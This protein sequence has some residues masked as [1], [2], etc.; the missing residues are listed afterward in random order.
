MKPMSSWTRRSFLSTA[1]VAAPAIIT[2]AK[3]AAPDPAVE[4]AKVVVADALAALGGDKFLEMK[5]RV[6]EGRA[7]SFY[8]SRLAGLSRAKIYTRYLDTTSDKG[9]A[10]RE[11]QAFGKDEDQAVLFNE[12]GEGWEITFRG[13]RPLPP[14][15]L[16]R[17]IDSTPRSVL[18]I[19]RQRLQEK[20]LIMEFTG[21]DVLVNE[22]VNIVEFTDAQNK[23]V[24][25]YFHY[26]TKLPIQQKFYRRDPQ[27]K[28]RF[29]E[30]TIF[31]KYRDLG[32]GVKWP[33]AQRRERDGEKIFELFAEKV[34][35]NQNL[36]DS[37]FLLPA[38]I[39]R[40]NP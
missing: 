1:V 24:T 11:R 34:T 33:L 23:S 16:Q 21:S 25:V 36:T 30:I 39:K 22:P 8:N 19:F 31:S 20:G 12:N 29:E 10:V 27:T 37:L 6:E 9:L 17:Y 26:S 7:Y 35:I 32:G 5:D 2:S 18:Y 14:A 40:L 38:D 28:E 13:A 4:K 15:T 3:G